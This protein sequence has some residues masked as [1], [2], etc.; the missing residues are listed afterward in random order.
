[1]Q[2]NAIGVQ[3][4]VKKNSKA[5]AAKT[6]AILTAGVLGAS[7]AVSWITKPDAMKQVV[8]EYGGKGKYAACYAAGLAILSGI[9]ALINTVFS[10]AADKIKEA[11]QPKAVN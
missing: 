11:K 8:K 1:M 6:G 2:V 3:P 9:G 10:V 4:P 7:T 5:R